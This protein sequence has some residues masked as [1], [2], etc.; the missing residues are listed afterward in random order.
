MKAM[1]HVRDLGRL[2]ALAA[3]LIVAAA[4]G[5]LYAGPLASSSFDT[6]DEEW[7]CVSTLG[8]W[9]SVTWSPTGGNPGGHVSGSDEDAG[10]FGFG[11]P[12][13][14]G[15]D[16]GDAY[17]QDLTFD[18]QTDVAN[19]VGGWVGLE[20]NDGIQIT[21]AYAAPA[22]PNAW[23]GR[24]V[25]LSEADAW[26]YVDGGDPVTQADMV[27]ILGDLEGLA[28]AAEFKEGLDETSRLDNVFMTPE[29]AT[30]ALVGLGAAGLVMRR[31]RRR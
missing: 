13:K 12:A 20:G 31:R 19:P 11:A 18:I 29:P 5:H 26:F 27:A 17:G 4:A 8:N 6:G 21:C 1:S 7:V 3:G 9:W 15:G 25:L 28:I 2:A 14:F 30:L 10:A 24:S 16:K 22:G 23:Y